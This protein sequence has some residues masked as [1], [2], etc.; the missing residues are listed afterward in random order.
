MRV[1]MP[2]ANAAVLPVPDWLWAIRLTGLRACTSNQL[3]RHVI[4]LVYAR[5][6]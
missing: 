3:I 1:R 5:N 6:L 2:I 4:V